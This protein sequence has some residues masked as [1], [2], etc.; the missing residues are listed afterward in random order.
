MEDMT[1][2]VKKGSKFYLILVLFF[3][4]LLVFSSMTY[5]VEEN[6]YAY[7]TQLSKFSRIEETAGLKFKTP[8]IEDVTELPK[9]VM[10]YDIPPSDVITADKKT[11]VVDSFAVWKIDEPLTFMR[12]VAGISEMQSRINASVYNAVRNTM[13]TLEQNSIISTNKRSVQDI[14]DKITKIVNEQLKS[15]G[16]SVVAAEIKRIDLPSS[17]E[18]AVYSRMISE[19]NQMAESYRA[20]GKLEAEKIKNETDKQVGIILSK[21]EADA[22]ELR[23]EGEAEYMSILSD[24]FKTTERQE[25]YEFMRGLDA[26]KVSMKGEKTLFLPADSFIARMLLGN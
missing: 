15:Y 20:G 2:R 21:S 19:R 10:L 5:V 1:Q 14:N 18:Q 6:E 8:F 26:L 9:Y 3:I 7:V 12:T 22:A 13:G 4:A 24:A 17:N 11:L 16:V 25:F 23:G